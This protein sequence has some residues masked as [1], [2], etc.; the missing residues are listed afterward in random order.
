MNN[1]IITEYINFSKQCINH[2]FKLI[3]DKKYNKDIVNKLINVYIDSRYY[4][5]TNNLPLTIRTN[6]N[7][8]S[9]E[10]K[11]A[12]KDVASNVIKIFNFIMYFDNV[13]E[14]ESTVRVIEA[15]AKFRTNIL[16]IKTN[17]KFNNTLL[18]VIKDDLIKKKEFIDTIDSDKFSFE[19]LLTTKDKV[20]D[21]IVNQNL[22]FPVVYNSTVIDKVFKSK[23]LIDKRSIV[24]YNFTS[25]QILKD[26]I[27]GSYYE[28]LI[29]YP[30]KASANPE[31]LEQLFNIINNE[32]LL[33]R[34]VIKINFKDFL[35]EKEIIYEYM[36][37][38]Y[39][40]A[41]VLENGF[42]EDDYNLNLLRVFKYIIINRRNSFIDVN[43]YKNI[44]KVD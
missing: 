14:C 18:E 42:I 33:S 11:G 31:K 21:V 43:S 36:R 12:D 40:F 38:G 5:N 8:A 9:E 39:K 20:Y 16:D 28:Y 4:T 35:N 34:I 19:T 26:L 22:K 25:L 29:T 6:L 41:A 7:K 2:Y 15:I 3:M 17:E 32:M 23:D 24:E 27:S 37:L 44:I 10:F 1:N 13:V 30:P